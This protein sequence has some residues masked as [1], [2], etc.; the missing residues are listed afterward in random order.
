MHGLLGRP[1]QDGRAANQLAK[2]KRELA[3]SLSLHFRA[4]EG[5]K[6]PRFASAPPLAPMLH[7]APL[8]MSAAEMLY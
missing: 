5:M 1:Q 8:L 7:T 6:R 4:P 2:Y 3:P